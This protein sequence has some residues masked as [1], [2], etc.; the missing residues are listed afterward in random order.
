[1]NP[2]NESN[3]STSAISGFLQAIRSSSILSERQLK[4]SKRMWPMG[5]IPRIRTN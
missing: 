3:T 1:M 5:S 2:A 4:N